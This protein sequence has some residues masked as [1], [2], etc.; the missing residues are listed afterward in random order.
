MIIFFCRWAADI[1]AAASVKCVTAKEEPSSK[2]K[3]I[4][5]GV[6]FGHSKTPFENVDSIGHRGFNT[7]LPTDSKRIRDI[8]IASHANIMEKLF[9]QSF[10]F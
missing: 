8:F 3:R 2:S 10:C 5:E 9:V 7:V 6:I 4:T 1:L